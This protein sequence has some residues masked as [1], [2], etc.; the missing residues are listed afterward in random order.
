MIAQT[1]FGALQRE[2][3][4]LDTEGVGSGSNGGE[5]DQNALYYIL[6]EFSI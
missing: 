6:K 1:V 2:G 4:N 3:T 5:Y